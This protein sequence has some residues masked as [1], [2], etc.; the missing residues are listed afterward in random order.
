MNH[1][2]YSLN[3]LKGLGLLQLKK[4]CDMIGANVLCK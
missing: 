3:I 4:Q 1:L 2:Y